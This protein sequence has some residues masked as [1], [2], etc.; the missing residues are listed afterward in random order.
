[1]KELIIKQG[2]T[3][4]NIMGEVIRIDKVCKK[5]LFTSPDTGL[6]FFQNGTSTAIGHGSD[7]VKIYKV[8]KGFL[9]CKTH[10]RAYFQV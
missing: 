3:Y 6:R 5:S 10:T 8:K 1:M 4:I 2:G 7:L 9:I